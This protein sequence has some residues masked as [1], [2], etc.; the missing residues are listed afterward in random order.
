MKPKRD[1]KY[2]STITK[3]MKKHMCN[4]KGKGMYH[5]K[6]TKNRNRNRGLLLPDETIKTAY[7][8]KEVSVHM[9]N[10]CACDKNSSHHGI[11]V[12]SVMSTGLFGM[13]LAPSKTAPA[14]LEKQL[15]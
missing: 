3:Q 7:L 10:G 9:T 5:Y 11:S 6:D 14:P 15:L 1:E 8:K 4:L 12:I 13:I 2:D